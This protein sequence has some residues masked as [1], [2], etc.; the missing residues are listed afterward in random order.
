V[1]QPYRGRSS[2]SRQGRTWRRSLASYLRLGLVLIFTAVL[3]VF[4]HHRSRWNIPRVNDPFPP[5]VTGQADPIDGDSLGVGDEEVR[6]QGIDAPEWK[7]KCSRAGASWTCGLAA[8]DEL[9]RVIG[10]SEVTCRISKRDVYG[11]LLGNCAAN[12]RDLNAHMVASGMA[13]AYGAYNGEQDAARSSK[14]G[15]WAGDFENPRDWRADNA[16]DGGR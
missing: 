6:L 2:R 8:R 14:T 11:R 13:V 15:I 10:T 4:G 9:A 5:S 3:M 7:Q 1:M 16:A 12:G